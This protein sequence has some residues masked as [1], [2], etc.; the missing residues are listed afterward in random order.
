MTNSNTQSSQFSNVFGEKGD[1]KSNFIT[2]NNNSSSN[3]DLN[4]PDFYKM[5]DI[6]KQRRL[7]ILIKRH[8]F[9]LFQKWDF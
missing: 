5:I 9:L 3:M 1:A 6:E 2:L 8:L 7:V 4:I